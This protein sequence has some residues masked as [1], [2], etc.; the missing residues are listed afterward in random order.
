MAYSFKSSS[1]D[2]KRKGLHETKIDSS[3]HSNELL[4]PEA[5]GITVIHY[6]TS[7]R[8]SNTVYWYGFGKAG[9]PGVT[10]NL[11]SFKINQSGGEYY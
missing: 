3:S 8:F 10:T 1:V 7:T 2:L 9:I 4:M 6:Y 11:V 5:C